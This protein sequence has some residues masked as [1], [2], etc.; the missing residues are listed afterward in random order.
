[1]CDRVATSKEHVPPKCLFPEDKDLPAGVSLRKDLITVPSCDEHNT[2]KSNDDE[3]LMYLLCMTIS[4]NS[5][6]FSQFKTKIARAVKRNPKLMQ[7]MQKDGRK[8][9]AVNNEG[10]ATNTVIN[11]ADTDRVQNCFEHIAHA[12]Y[13]HHFGNKFSGDLRFLQDWAVTPDKKQEYLVNTKDGLV[14]VLDF[15]KQYFAELEHDGKNAS[16]FRYRFEEPDEHGISS[17]AL[18][19]YERT[20]VFIAYGPNKHA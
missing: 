12:L 11:H 19:F 10:V 16:V 14:P 2:T 18:Q 9:I 17:V 8:V 7:S 5:T 20:N 13:Y 6:A 3:Y 4:N 15:V 1:M